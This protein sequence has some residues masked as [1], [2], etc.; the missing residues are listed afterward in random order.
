[1]TKT[2]REDF[3]AALDANSAP[4]SK[5]MGIWEL[6]DHV[7]DEVSGG[8]NFWQGGPGPADF[9]QNFSCFA[10]NIGDFSMGTPPKG[11]GGNEN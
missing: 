11:G 1:M 8:D 2:R 5:S 4:E 10:Q 9:A 3:D 7:L 6:P